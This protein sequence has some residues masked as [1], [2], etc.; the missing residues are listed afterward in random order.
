MTHFTKYLTSAPIVAILTL[1]LLA[2]LLIELNYLFPG[3]QYGTY[4]KPAF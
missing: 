1:V 3:L 2:T 4:F